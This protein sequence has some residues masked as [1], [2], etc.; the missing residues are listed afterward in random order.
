MTNTG[1]KFISFDNMEINY[2]KWQKKFTNDVTG[3]VLIIHGM[4]EH[5]LRYENFANYL[6]ECGY[7]VY[8]LDYRGHGITGLNSGELGSLGEKGWQSVIKDIHKMVDIIKNEFPQLPLYL[9]GHSM[10]SLLARTCIIQY[11]REFK[12]VILSGT[13]NG[14]S[15]IIT[16]IGLIISKIMVLIEGSKKTSSFMTRLTFGNYNKKF[17]TDRFGF[18]WL[19]RD[20]SIVQ[21]YTE[22]PLCGFECTWGFYKEMLGGIDFISNPKNIS[23]VP[24]DLNVLILY[25][26]DD[27]VGN[28]GSDV[29]KVYDIYEKRGMDNIKLKSYPQYRHEI[30]NELN[31]EV[32]YED[33]IDWLQ[34]F[35]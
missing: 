17:S 18:Q 26:E 28:Y 25:G 3:V 1:L 35:I 4:A 33:I 27:P 16:K 15:P 23:Q 19:T 8:A 10:G 2:Y 31:K 9:F 14:G 6:N 22:D 11:G 20:E 24:V 34:Q 7:I 32:V 13:T 30:L 21:K 5:A 29:K 12:G